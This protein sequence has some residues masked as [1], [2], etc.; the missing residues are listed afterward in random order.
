MKQC[1]LWL[2]LILATLTG[3]HTGEPATPEETGGMP[4]GKWDFAFFTPKALY[5]DV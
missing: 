3:C 1:C 5:A 2:F 4:Y